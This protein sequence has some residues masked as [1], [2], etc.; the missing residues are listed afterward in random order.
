[1]EGAGP[2]PTISQSRPM[3][4]PILLVVIVVGAGVDSAAR[5]G[6]VSEAGSAA[7]DETLVPMV[8]AVRFRGRSSVADG[9]VVET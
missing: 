3:Y 6:S 5:G 9:L 4:F 7:S 2:V 1:M 8:I